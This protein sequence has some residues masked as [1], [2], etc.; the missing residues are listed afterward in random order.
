MDKSIVRYKYIN[1]G[2]RIKNSEKRQISTLRLIAYHFVRGKR[3]I[4]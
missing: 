3:F 2:P 1:I 4:L